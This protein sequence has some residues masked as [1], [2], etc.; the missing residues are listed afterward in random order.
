MADLMSGSY[1]Y[2]ALAKEYGNFIIPLIKIVVNGIDLVSKQKLAVSSARVTLSLEG[3]GMAVIKLSG[4]YD[5]KKHT[6][7][8][9][10]KSSFK[11]GTVV[12]LELGYGSKSLAVFKGY[13]AMLGCEFGEKSP[14]IVVTLMD[15]RR[16][17]MTS[18]ATY[19]LHDVKNYS[20]AVS[21][22]LKKYSKLCS[23]VVEAT[24]D[25]LTEMVSQ[26]QNDYLFITN[27]LICQGK[28][29]REFFILGDKVYFREPRKQKSPVITMQFGREL[30]ALK[31]DDEYRDLKVNVHGCDEDKQESVVGSAAVGKAKGQTSLIN[32]TP[33]LN[34]TDPTADS[35]KKAANRAKVIA[36]HIQWR[37][38]TGR[39]MCI[40]MPEIVPGRY[41]KVEKLDADLGD[42]SYYLKSVV[43]EWDEE[44]Y[45][46]M[47]DIE[48][49]K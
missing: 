47:F 43:H 46:T 8:S 29:N 23:P 24:S 22:I 11:V 5:E 2:E 45:I 40:G 39:G 15:A 19:R 12:V 49:F 31:A 3:A 14:Q 6:F 7:D 1:T 38:Q 4:L 28:V 44:H 10:A 17:M 21:Q 9:S 32:P 30:L 20:D 41:I 26:T 42:R 35:Q 48:G 37:A 18:G 36:E 16:L 25:N 27:E 13:V 33:E 34:L